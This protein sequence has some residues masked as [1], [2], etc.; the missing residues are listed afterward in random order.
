MDFTHTETR[1]ML[2]DYFRQPN[3]DLEKLLGLDLSAWNLS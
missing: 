1:R 2:A 3:K